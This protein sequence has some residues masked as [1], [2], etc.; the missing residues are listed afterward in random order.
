MRRPAATTYNDWLKF[1]Q[2]LGK[3]KNKLAHLH[4]M[5][6]ADFGFVFKEPGIRSLV[7]AYS[8]EPPRG[9]RLV[10]GWKPTLR[11]LAESGRL[12][13]QSADEDDQSA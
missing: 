6:D 11:R 4:E 12:A 8:A 1:C 9:W 7:V 5:E 3:R 13:L 2:W 10:K